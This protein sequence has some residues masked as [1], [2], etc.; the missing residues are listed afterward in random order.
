M[1][2]GTKSPK[3]EGETTMT[4]AYKNAE[5]ITEEEQMAALKR[6][7]ENGIDAYRNGIEEE[8]SGPDDQAWILEILS[9][10]DFDSM[11]EEYIYADTMVRDYMMKIIF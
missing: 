4:E 9:K 5:F 3:A 6:A 8:V 11:W 1:P 2:Q 7:L 10:P